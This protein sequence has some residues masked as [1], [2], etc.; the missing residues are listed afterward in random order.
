MLSRVFAASALALVAATASGCSGSGGAAPATITPAAVA[1]AERP[2][3]SAPA[4]AASSA[5]PEPAQADDGPAWLGVELAPAEPG[6]GGV[7]VKSV[8]THS[9]AESAGVLAGDRIL[10]VG[11]VDVA[12]PADVVRVV[13]LQRAGER[14]GLALVR[15]GAE[16]LIPV[17]L[18]ARP[19]PDQMLKLELGDGPAP[20]WRPLAT[21]RG[22][23]PATLAELKGR[24][25]VMEFW[26]SWC[27][28]CRMSAPK[29]TAWQNRYGAQGLTVIGITMDSPEV[30]LQAS[31]EMGMD[32]TVLSDPDG[33]T[34]RVY[35][36][37][38]LPTLFVIDRE[39]KIRE[40]LVGYSSE[41]L[42]KAEN[43]IRTLLANG[44]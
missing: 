32:Y 44:S 28:P 7:L 18:T 39:G 8:M 29:L 9:P 40:A 16:R 24:V 6:Q 4:A 17:V 3:E 12:R 30:A 27:M 42:R 5:K 11:A 1:S 43:T 36:A 13:S 33:E 25:V 41:G 31:V 38:A 19:D 2:A 10:R 23:V 26:A 14:L 34:T 15:E 35:K 22:S 37:F 21:V 20:A